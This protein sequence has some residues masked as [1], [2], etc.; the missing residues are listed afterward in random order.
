MSTQDF[1]IIFTSLRSIL[2]KQAAW[3]LVM[4]DA[5]KRYCLAGRTGPSALKAW[6]GKMKVKTLPVGWVQIGKSYV[7]YHLMGLGDV[8]A[9][10]CAMSEELKAHMQ[11]KTC[12]NFKVQDEAL[13]AQLDQLTERV[14]KQF[15]KAGFIE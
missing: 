1:A 8:G 9:A 7:S 3:L 4:E 11:G 5:P 10:Q 2:S 6:G 14:C 13:F 15:K 12:F